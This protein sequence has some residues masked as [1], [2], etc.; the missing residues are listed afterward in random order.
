MAEPLRILFLE[1][2]ARDVELVT[3]ALAAAGIDSRL[4]AVSKSNAVG[5]SAAASGRTRGGRQDEGRGS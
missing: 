2:D 3:G 5:P 1:D 4:E